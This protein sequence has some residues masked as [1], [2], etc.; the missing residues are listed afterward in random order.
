MSAAAYV[1]LIIDLNV[2]I[3]LL[4]FFGF[5]IFGCGRVCKYLFGLLEPYYR[6]NSLYPNT[7]TCFLTISSFNCSFSIS[8]G[9]SNGSPD[10]DGP[11]SL[12]LGTANRPIEQPESITIQVFYHLYRRPRVG[13]SRQRH[14][15]SLWSWPEL[16]L[17]SYTPRG[18]FRGDPNRALFANSWPCVSGKPAISTGCDYVRPTVLG[19]SQ[20]SQYPAG[21]SSPF[22]EAGW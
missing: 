5:F 2:C 7:R 14:G 15:D 22:R 18:C 21:A 9:R 16:H 4:C 11:N 13:R 12:S 20:V 10:G 6:K 17:L 19:Y 8:R 1:H 3:P